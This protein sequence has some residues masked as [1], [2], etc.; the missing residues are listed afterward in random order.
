MQR[1]AALLAGSLALATA[2]CTDGKP[3]PITLTAD[4]P[5]SPAAVPDADLK[6][7]ADGNNAFAVDLF[8][9]VAAGTHRDVVFSPLSIRTVLALTYAG[10]RGRTAEEMREVL[11]F[12]L[13]NDRL[14]AATNA[15]IRRLTG[16][17]AD[18]PGRTEI[19]NALWLHDKSTI[20]EAFQL[21]AD[22][23][24]A[25]GLNRVDFRSPGSAIDQIN[26]W[27]H[28]RTHGVIPDLVNEADVTEST[29]LVLVNAVYFKDDWAK[30]FQA[31]H[32]KDAPFHVGPGQTVPVR[33]MHASHEL[34]YAEADG[35]RLLVMPYSRPG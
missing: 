28:D 3:D 20:S 19:A 34:K 1:A 32:T 11:R 18:A 26:R 2:A 7:L 30:P 21:L 29:R 31:E 24:Y 10:T 14:H 33:M 35:V 15:T 16:G 23:H 27:V 25:A 8:K 6:A 22:R 4:A 5:A 17:P 13:P 12:T 9:R